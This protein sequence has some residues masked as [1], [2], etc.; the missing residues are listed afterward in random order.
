VTAVREV[1]VL[2]ELLAMVGDDHD[3]RT[4]QDAIPLELLEQRPELVVPAAD[5]AVV[6]PPEVGDLDGARRG[7]PELVPRQ[8]EGL[9]PARRQVRAHAGRRLRAKAGWWCVGAVWLHVVKISEE[10]EAAFTAYPVE[11]LPVDHPGVDVVPH[12]LVE[13][14]LEEGLEALGEVAG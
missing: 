13:G 6:E 7:G 8:R 14:Q 2:H 11:E 1:A 12:R 3:D 5:V 4:V 10:P 9:D